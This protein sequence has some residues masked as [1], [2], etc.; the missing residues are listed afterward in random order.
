MDTS[1]ATAR[2]RPAKLDRTQFYIVSQSIQRFD[3]YLEATRGKDSDR[4]KNLQVRRDDYHYHSEDDS[5][6]DRSPRASR[7]VDERSLQRGQGRPP[8]GQVSLAP[9]P[10]GV[11]VRARSR[12]NDGY[13]RAARPMGDRRGPDPA[14]DHDDDYVDEAPVDRR[15]RRGGVAVTPAQNRRRGYDD[16]YE[17]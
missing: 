1:T 17:Y 11:S 6:Y 4:A 10:R 5:I 15:R 16:D 12:Q 7:F 9:P 8:Q 14:E 3:D 2:H 13:E